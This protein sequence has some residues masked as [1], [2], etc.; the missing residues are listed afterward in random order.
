[1]KQRII[2]MI[3]CL[4]LLV[5]L[6]PSISAATTETKNGT[7]TTMVGTNSVGTMI[8]DELKNVEQ[9]A[10]DP[11]VLQDLTIE[12]GTA[13]VRFTTTEEAE[14]VVA[15]YEEASGRQVTSAKATVHKDDTTTALTL[16][17]SALPQYFRAEAFLLSAKDYTPLCES[18]S[19]PMYTQAFQELLQKSA[20]DFDSDRVLNLDEDKNT[21]FAV[22]GDDVKR[23]ESD[24]TV[25]TVQSAD[26]EALRY[27]IDNP[28]STVTSL[29]PGDFWSCE[30]A[31]E[32]LIVKVKSV[33]VQ[34]NQAIITGQDTSMEEVFDYA[35]IEGDAT[36]EDA[37]VDASQM[38]DGVTYNGVVDME[39]GTRA[40]SGGGNLKRGWSFSLQKEIKGNG[41]SAKVS[42]SLNLSVTTKLKYYVARSDSYI[43]FTQEYKMKV[44]GELENKLTLYEIPLTLVP[45]VIPICGVINIEVEPNLVAEFSATVSIDTSLTWTTGLTYEQGKGFRNASSKPSTSAELSIEGTLFIGASVNVKFCIISS[46]ICSIGVGFQAGAEINAKLTGRERENGKIHACDGCLDGSIHVVL[47]I[48]AS[49]ELFKVI[50]ISSTIVEFKLLLHDF[51]N[52]L[53]YHESGWGDCPHWYDEG[54]EPEKPTE[55]TE[56]TEPTDPAEPT[57]PTE[58][59]EVVASGTCGE[60]LTWTLDKNG[61]LTISGAGAMYDYSYGNSAPWRSQGYKSKVKKVIINESVASIGAYAFYDC[62]GLTSITI[63]SG[64]TS[65]GVDAF[66]G[67]SSLTSITIPSSV[68]S[69]GGTA[70]WG[71]SGLASITIPSGVTNIGVEAF[72]CC[73]GLTSITIPSSVTSIG[74]E[75]FLWCSGLTGIWVD[76]NN[77]TYA[78]DNSGVLFNKNKT[79][80]ICCPAGYSG[81]YTIPSSVTNIGAYAFDYCTGLTSITIPSSVT[82]IGAFAFEYCT[83][84]TS[85]TIPS[86]V[87]SIEDNAFAHCTGLTSITIPSSVTNIGAFA[88]DD[89]TGLTS[90]TIPSSVTNI[91]AYAFSDCT[92]L[93]S[94]TIPLSVTSIGWYTF[95]GCTG[96]TSITIPSSVTNIGAYAFSDCTGLTSV[97]I[98]S[99]VTSIGIH[100]FSGCSGL[101]SITIPSSVTSIGVDAFWNCSGLT[102][103]TIPSGVTSI[104]D[105]AFSGCSGLTSIYFCGNT[106]SFGDDSFTG[107]TATAYYPTGNSTWTDEV[108][109][110]YG[111]NLTWTPWTPTD[112]AAAAAPEMRGLHTGKENGSTVS[113]SDLTPGAQYVLIVSRD[114]NSDLLASGNLL[115]IAQAAANA[116]GTLTFTPAPP[117]AAANAFVGLYGQGETIS[118]GYEPCDGVNCPG[119]AFADMPAKGNWAHDPIDWAVSNEITNGTSASTFS[120][121]EG[122]TRAQVVTF[123]WRA[124][125]QPAPASSTNPFTDVKAGAYYYNAVLWAVEKGITNG[126]SDKTF[127]PDETCTRA[128]IVT[129]LWRYEGQPAPTSTNNPFADVRTS[130]YFGS[131]VLWAVE[132]D[133]TNGTSATTFDPEDTCTRAQVVTFLYRN[134]LKESSQ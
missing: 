2:S 38:A 27:V 1:M 99:S 86:S 14:L 77:A 45:I 66:H 113:F 47:R 89:C 25:N 16:D 111:G 82:N 41:F 84:L 32:I 75:A 80:L 22:Y 15:I 122:C 101:T 92:G 127:S 20:D 120:P 28:D 106:P 17:A 126:T 44:K 8:A 97:T 94:V 70:F 53:T 51:Y 78:S 134:V 10:G 19:T 26:D 29:Q 73:S 131:A 112:G 85:I 11:N 83:G 88:F 5:G 107:V 49:A 103:I 129:F 61:D 55:P 72:G 6:M 69:I 7:K 54:S 42:A 63:S 59:S 23:S 30:G 52:S 130:A 81:A 36:A 95:S 105:G 60:N 40:V 34:G 114:K 118:G 128:Q 64:V 124:A 33:T 108:K 3:L 74:D 48:T 43:S 39:Q 91:G 37:V 57:E 50:K 76:S 98:P 62:Y 12:N 35:K 18:L 46:Y 9:D 132:K 68:T 104:G 71:C 31:E 123:L 115:F 24:G 13:T 110:A 4:A 109:Q 125:G 121:E 117:E 58:P 133:I 21:N 93:T 65:I 90:I 87:T 102:S 56:P 116:D 79:S 100:T 96:L 67:C 119:K